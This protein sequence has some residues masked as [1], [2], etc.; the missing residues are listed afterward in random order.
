MSNSH[1]FEVSSN[2][3]ESRSV[4][5]PGEVFLVVGDWFVDEHW[6]CGVHRSSS[7]S[8]TGR[9]HVRA[10]HSARSTVR[11]F[12]GAGRSAQF[13]HQLYQSSESNESQTSVIGL[14]FWHRADTEALLS[15]F[16]FRSPAQTPFRLTPPE[17][18]A[19]KGIELI[20]M[21]DALNVND[22]TRSDQAQ[23]R[24]RDSREYTTRVI[25]IYT[26]GE[27]DRVEYDRI[28]WERRAPAKIPW[29][30][31][32]RAEL[33]KL[34]DAQLN[35]RSVRAILIKDLQKGVI[36]D[37]IIEWLIKWDSGRS[38][39][40]VST[41]KWR[42]DW[43]D[44]LGRRVD[45]RLVMIPQVAAQAAIHDKREKDPKLSP[46]QQFSRWITRS[47]KPSKEAIDLIDKFAEFSRAKSIFI[48]PHGFSA[49]AC[50]CSSKKITSSVIQSDVKPEKVTVEMGYASILFPALVACLSLNPDLRI[51]KKLMSLS[52]RAAYEWIEFEAQR[53]FHPTDWNPNLDW[54]KNWVLDCMRRFVHQPYQLNEIPKFGDVRDCDWNEERTQWDQALKGVGVIGARGTRDRKLEL[55]R[56]MVEIDG[57]VCCEASTRKELKQLLHGVQHFSK[58]PRHHA[59]CMLLA[60]PGS[61]K[62][63]LA[64]RLAETANLRFVPFNITQMRSKGDI[65]ECLDTIVATQA[66]NINQPLM[67]F[68]DEINAKLENASVYG[69]FLTPLEDGT[70]VHSGR[71]FNIKPC[72]WVFAGTRHPELE[73]SVS[74]DGNRSL[75]PTRPEKGSDFVSRLTL[76]VLK[77]TSSGGPQ[78][79]DAEDIKDEEILATEKVY[80]G[81][82][83]LRHEFPDVRRVSEHVLSAF[84][85]LPRSTTVR[86]IK[87]FVRRFSD[88]QYGEVTSRSVPD[89]WPGD[90][91]D[92]RIHN[93]WSDEVERLPELDK[94]D[95]S[96]VTGTESERGID[97]HPV[98]KAAKLTAGA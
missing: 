94:P 49:M 7:S 14:G 61:G 69:A 3:S 78:G 25:R 95:I 88:I 50:E 48:L 86:E 2:Q 79:H 60:S 47:G 53:V 73:D 57:Y 46:A 32:N 28:D 68:I 84:R 82:C 36:T 15:L 6:V 72:M 89:R 11:A 92:G 18:N 58:Y 43:L 42:P 80:L 4:V 24:Y 71:T 30:N 31:S 81:A 59:S 85:E 76:R 10:L 45:L 33:S 34:L 16:D 22:G 37:E 98:S 52:L 17:P 64:K 44:G 26:H 91:D 35:H 74:V 63:F 55:W 96:I 29:E 23:I 87:H 70:Y 93:R 66:E 9:S 1:G 77:L 97:S 21:N 8:R 54:S 40:F 65:L 41:K 83:M 90:S 19:P 56:A 27:K 20:N 38:P 62:T 13:L 67:V 51:D 5:N 12:C 75:P 39:W